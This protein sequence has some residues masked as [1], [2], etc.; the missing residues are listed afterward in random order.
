[1]IAV[2]VI[3]FTYA[4]GNLEAAD[5]DGEEEDIEGK[6]GQADVPL[7]LQRQSSRRTHEDGSCTVSHA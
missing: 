6:E 5:E 7:V 3:I 2:T 1:M 4:D